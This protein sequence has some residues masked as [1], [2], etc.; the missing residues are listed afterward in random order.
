MKFENAEYERN[1]KSPSPPRTPSTVE[2]GIDVSEPVKS[3]SE[4][5]NDDIQVKCVEFY[6]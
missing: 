4:K 1:F 6:F 3:Q 2:S 5:S